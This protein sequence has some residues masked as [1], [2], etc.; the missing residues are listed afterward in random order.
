MIH[1][2]Y[3]MCDIY[4]Y[5]LLAEQSRFPRLRSLGRNARIAGS[6]NE[7]AGGGMCNLTVPAIVS[8]VK[9]NEISE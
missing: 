1:A 8:F 6:G 7:I 2:W 4:L 9:R 5:Y 3:G